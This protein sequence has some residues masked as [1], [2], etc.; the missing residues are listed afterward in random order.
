HA[1]FRHDGKMR[2]ANGCQTSAAD[3]SPATRCARFRTEQVQ[4]RACTDWDLPDHLI[5]TRE[6]RGRNGEPKR[7][8]SLQVNDELERSRLQLRQPT[9]YASCHIPRPPAP[10]W[11]SVSN[12]KSISLSVPA[13]T[14]ISFR[15]SACAA[16]SASLFVGLTSGARGKDFAQKPVKQLQTPRVSDDTMTDTPVAL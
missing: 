14:T 11:A 9:R 1:G 2:V 7:L 10:F 13:P 12:A 5:S 8:G 16:S 15:P 6:Q 4:Q 3:E